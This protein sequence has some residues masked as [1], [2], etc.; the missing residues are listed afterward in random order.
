[1]PVVLE[2]KART[3]TAVLRLPV[4]LLNKAD[5]PT[6][7][8]YVAVVTAPSVPLPN[9]VLV[10]SDVRP[11]PTFTP[12]KVISWAIVLV[13]V[14]SAM[15]V[16]PMVTEL[17]TRPAFG[18][19]VQL[20]S[21]PLVGVPRTGVMSVGVLLKTNRPVPVSSVMAAR[22]FALVGLVNHAAMPAAKTVSALMLYQEFVAW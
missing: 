4:V 22:R 15:A 14:P 13:A 16:P 17:F 10:A 11:R 8:E 5:A 7:V 1:M 12:L 9:A 2:T 3:P 18:K 6:A 19:P 21:V 20:V